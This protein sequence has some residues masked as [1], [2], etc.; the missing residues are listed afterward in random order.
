MHPPDKKLNFSFVAASNVSPPPQ[1]KVGAK[2]FLSDSLQN[3][4]NIVFG[5]GGGRDIN[6]PKNEVKFLAGLTECKDDFGG[7]FWQCMNEEQ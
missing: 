5:E 2:L 1:N 3:L 7:C 6:T 4:C